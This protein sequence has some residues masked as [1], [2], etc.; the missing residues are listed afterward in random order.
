MIWIIVIVIAATIF[1]AASSACFFDTAAQAVR[2][3]LNERIRVSIST[4]RF[5]T[6]VE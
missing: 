2:H 6:D 4:E 1:F 3:E 5:L